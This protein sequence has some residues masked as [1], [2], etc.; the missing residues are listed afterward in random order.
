MTPVGE[1]RFAP[2]GEPRTRTDL[3][4]DALKVAILD[5]SLPPGHPLSERD[6]AARMGVSKT[7][8][9]EALK[10]L[11]STGLVELGAYQQVTVRR[12]D[13][14]LV[15]ELY[16][17]RLVIEPHAVGLAAHGRGRTPLPEARTALEEAVVAASADDLAT[18][19]LANRRFHRLLYAEC[20]N[21][22]LV[23]QLDQLRD[24]TALAATVGWRQGRTDREEAAEHA[25]ILAAFEQ[26]DEELATDLMRAHIA[27]AR[28]HL[29][30]V[31]PTVE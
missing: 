9:R 15:S 13:S 4:V 10:L 21:R 19:S 3:V 29:L 23:D 17:A 16:H 31:L 18:A 14:A 26:G 11:R 5:G 12:V 25:A 24:L 2:L 8:V 1:P 28:T 30:H 7:P 6:L 22:F 20:G 27:T